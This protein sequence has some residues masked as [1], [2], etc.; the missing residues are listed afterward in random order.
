[1]RRVFAFLLAFAVVVAPVG[2]PV[3]FAASG[4]MAAGGCDCGGKSPVDVSAPCQDECA[5]TVTVIVPE[6]A[7]PT[8]PF[9]AIF[10]QRPSQQVA[11]HNGPPDTRPPNSQSMI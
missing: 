2:V 10:L 4:V 5:A 7:T 1:M 9:S 11:G 6:S 8:S 3:A